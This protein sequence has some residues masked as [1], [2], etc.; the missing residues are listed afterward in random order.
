LRVKDNG[1]GITPDLL[2]C[3]FDLFTQA[4]RSLDRSQ[5]G[6]GIGLALVQQLTE[7]H[8][9]KVEVF[10]TLRQGSEF[11]VRLPTESPKSMQAVQVAVVVPNKQMIPLRILIVDDNVD[12]VLSF[13]MLLKET[14]NEVRTAH[15]GPT[16]VKI[17]MEYIPDVVLLDIGLPGLNG[18]EVAKQIRNQPSLKNV[19]LVALTGYG[20]ESD[21]QASMEAGFSHHLIKPAK[22]EQ[23][24]KILANVAAQCS[25]NILRT[26]TSQNH[27]AIESDFGGI[28]RT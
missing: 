10:S 23:V 26:E 25:T 9:G 3:I 27:S 15:D 11:V 6:L 13:S 18:Y 16:A 17:A 21:R 28:D 20:L 2:P 24:R 1:V 7:M 8:G 22:L 4:E 14:G 12:T 5:G 19:V